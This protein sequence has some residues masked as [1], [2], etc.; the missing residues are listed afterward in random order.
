MNIAFSP[1]YIDDDV[2]AEVVSSLKSGWITSGPKVKQLEE[3]AAELCGLEHTV[4][5]NSWTSG[6]ALAFK[7]LGI[8][9]GDEVIVPAY[10]YAATVLSVL[11][12]GAKPVMVDVLEDFTI[13]P[14]KVRAAITPATKAIFPV[15]IG[16]WPSDYN[17]LKEI[18]NSDSVRSIFQAKNDVQKQMGRPMLVAD[19][20]HSF[21]ATYNQKPVA[22][23]PDIALF[24]LNAV[25]NITSGEGGIISLN[26]P[27]PF[28]QNEVYK[29]MKLNA[30][31]GQTKD[32][33][34]KSQSGE[35]KYDIVSLG[36]KANMP[37][38]C[39]AI[40]LAQMRK[41]KDN[42]LPA[43][44]HVVQHYLEFFSK[45]EWAILPPVCDK[46]RETSFHLFQ[47]RIKGLS[48][49]QRDKIIQKLAGAGIASNVHFIP[50]PMLTFFKNLGYKIEDYPQ[51]YNN[52][53]NEISLPLYPQLTDNECSYIEQQIEKAYT[54]VLNDAAI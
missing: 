34:S 42:L 52:Y 26:L 41:Y 17:A 2:I 11:H 24:S 50:I 30:L 12:A 45:K 51:A 18:I 44:E 6:A 49:N 20:A 8:G 53:I 15:D 16:G 27:A 10:T 28:S 47:L 13:D 22:Q 25:K 54:E 29:W 36:L 9:E 37:D 43:R 46:D 35:W 7:W 32:A 3:L 48:E 33:F 14:E 39:A 19:A 21:G 4:C 31:N 23:A 1:P 38:V 40:G 5:V